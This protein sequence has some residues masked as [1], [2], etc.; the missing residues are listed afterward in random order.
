MVQ[1]KPRDDPHIADVVL[2]ADHV[3][4]LDR[5]LVEAGRQRWTI[6]VRDRTPMLAI[7][8]TLGFKIIEARTEWQGQTADLRRAPETGCG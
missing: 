2:D 6:F 5:A 3:V 7:N 8:N 4:E 1:A